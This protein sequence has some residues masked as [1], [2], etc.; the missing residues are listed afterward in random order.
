MFVMF[1]VKSN[2][3]FPPFLVFI[4]DAWNDW[5]EKHQ[6]QWLSVANS[7][8]TRGELP[9]AMGLPWNDIPYRY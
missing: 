7:T 4:L 9:I 3:F 6:I 1:D 2:D 8:I 5:G